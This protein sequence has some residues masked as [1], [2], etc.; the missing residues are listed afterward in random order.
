MKPRDVEHVTI[1][2]Q[3]NNKWS[4][5]K[6]WFLFRVRA[7]G[8]NYRVY[9]PRLFVSATQNKSLQTAFYT[10]WKEIYEFVKGRFIMCRCFHLDRPQ[11]ITWP[12]FHRCN[13]LAAFLLSSGCLPLNLTPIMWPA[14]VLLTMDQQIPPI[15]MK[16]LGHMI[17]INQSRSDKFMFWILLKFQSHRWKIAK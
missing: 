3:S 7:K 10:S 8:K 4:S 16:N 17:K 12:K 9:F 15:R 14:L 2:G 6:Q 13:N 11:H 1:M 5:D